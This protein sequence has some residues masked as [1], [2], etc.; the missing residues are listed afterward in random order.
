MPLKLPVGFLAIVLFAASGSESWACQDGEWQPLAPMSIA[1]QE[2]GA[3][4]IE[5]EVYVV[6]G[7]LAGFPLSATATVEVYDIA[8]DRWDF[9]PFMPVALD[10]M[11]VSAV[12]G[13]LYV[14][15]GYSA[16]FRARDELWIYDPQ[17]REWAPGAP[18]PEERGAGW[19]VEHGGRI[20]VFGGVNASGAATR[21]TCIYDPIADEWTNGSDI[22]TAREHL[23]AVAAG[24]Y[25]YVIGGRAGASSA[26]N[27]RYDP[28]NDEW[29]VMRPMPTARSAMAA[30]ALGD[31]IYA[32]GGEIPVLF[33]VN[34][35]YD[36]VTDTWSTG[37]PMTIP[38]HG[39]A[40]VA[41]ADRILTPGGGVIQGLSP[42]SAVDSFVPL[43]ISVGETGGLPAA[44]LR[45]LPIHP[46]PFN[47]ATTIPFSLAGDASVNMTIHDA[48]GRRVRTLIRRFLAGGE[49]QTIWDGRDE[50]GAVLESGIYLVRLEASG[51][52]ASQ[53]V[54]L[55]K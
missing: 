42:T 51:S 41:L 12:D 17:T 24:D 18:I 7:L 4:R 6:G 10:H 5:G 31:C 46:N 52:I 21:T 1:R 11:M 20:Y 8:G 3:A 30:A 55:A 53:K 49:H 47:P 28:A 22:P 37:A 9:A 29:T 34:E 50:S 25:I 2:T 16:D 38:R 44:G 15:G 43:T 40:A 39:V 35:S 48:G 23:N 45:L 27:E 13:R 33:A 32:A 14:I 19:A 54:I 26:A 36:T